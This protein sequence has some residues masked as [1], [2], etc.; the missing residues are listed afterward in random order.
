MINDFKKLFAGGLRIEC[1]TVLS[2]RLCPF[3]ILSPGNGLRQNYS[4]KICWYSLH[5]KK[6]Y[7]SLRWH[8]ITVNYLNSV[9]A[10]LTILLYFVFFGISTLI[11]SFLP[12]FF[13]V[14]PVNHMHLDAQPF[15]FLKNYQSVLL[16][17]RVEG[18]AALS[19]DRVYEC[20]TWHF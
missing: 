20:T 14:I 19:F 7:L 5:H 15:A 10:S 6:K 12:T 3:V 13:T 2:S 18:L 8:L 9:H 11:L 16:L 17:S 4:H 1:N